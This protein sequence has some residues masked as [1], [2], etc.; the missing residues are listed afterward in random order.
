VRLLPVFLD[1]FVAQ[2][3]YRFGREARRDRR[4]VFGQ[5]RPQLLL[6]AAYDRPDFP[7]RV[8]EIEG[9]GAYTVQLSSSIVRW[10]IVSL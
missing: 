3:R 5:P 7:E 6:S 8:I 9:Y 10:H 1:D 4:V 2:G